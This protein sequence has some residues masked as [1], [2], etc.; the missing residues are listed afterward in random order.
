[1]KLTL[2]LDLFRNMGLRY[3]VF[4]VLHVV[5][6]RLGIYKKKF[7][8][9]PNFKEFIELNAWRNNAPPFF[10][11]NKAALQLLPCNIEKLEKTVNNIKKG[12]YIFFSK[13]VFD[14]GVDYDWMTNPDSGYKYDPQLHFT[15]IKDFTKDSGDIKYV[16]EKARFSF[17]YD[18]IR[19]D[20]H[21]NKDQSKFV[22]DQIID[23]IDKN[24]INQGP[25][26][27]C[28]QE[29]S[30]RILNW[31][32]ALYYYRD[33]ETLTDAIFKKIMN[34]IYWQIQHVYHNIYFSRIAV[35][36]NH[37][38]TETLM[39]YLSNLLFSFIPET[40]AWS[41]KGKRWFEEEIA[42]QIYEDGTYLQHSM[43]YH[44]I[45]IQ[46]LT[47]AIRL[48]ELN[49]DQ[50]QEVVYEKAKK[51]LYFLD[52]CLN[53][54]DGTLP[55]YGHNDGALFFKL[56]D[57]DYRDYRSQLDD[58]RA[59]LEN[60]IAYN[61]D[62]YNWYGIRNP[63]KIDSLLLGTYTF[64]NGG[65][66]IINQEHNKTF[67]RCTS[68][69]DRPAQSDNLHLDLWADG[70]NILRDSG[71]YKYNTTKEYSS[72]FNGTGGHNTV[73]LD[74]TDQMLKGGRFIW[75]YWIKNAK[76]KLTKSKEEFVF[77]GQINAF[78]YIGK[79]IVH[80]REV[81]KLEKS[82]AWEIFDTFENVLNKE[83]IQYWHINP[84]VKEKLI[85]KSYDANGIELNPIIEKKWYSS[86]YGIKEPS[87]RISFKTKFGYL[88]TRIEYLKT[89]N[90]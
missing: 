32:F 19:Y 4:R 58:L 71:T 35:R 20:Y 61:T 60:K 85:I 43:N 17:L 53:R 89:P 22:F 23:F 65:Y 11:K 34:A 18:L 62:S 69:K 7:P 77:Q 70:I 66:Y 38:I 64:D 16:W 28:S 36:N 78:K 59:V 45:V 39:L 49:K 74:G 52:T 46:L 84:E 21:S 79:N 87:I 25:N 6:T 33:A 72:Y 2:Y 73:S 24:P 83:I 88:H 29:T 42:Y 51:S 26:Y 48:A 86:Y 10:F 27:K 54:T 5:K 14:L 80:K 57:N 50:F 44:R 13:K 81:V 41:K 15:S 47:W 68:Y 76:A 90:H 67:I 37:A 63:D 9:N 1:M 30:L 56:T 12:K 75:F 40:K 3:V 31:T 8:V 82:C 55:N